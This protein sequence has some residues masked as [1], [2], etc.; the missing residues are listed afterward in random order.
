MSDLI[1]VGL[2]GARRGPA[3]VAGLR[4]IE[5]V[6]VAA[7]CDPNVEFLHQRADRFGITRRHTNFREMLEDAVDFVVLGTPMHLHTPQ[8]LEALAAGKHVLSEVTAAVSMEQCR[9]LVE[10]V[11]RARAHGLKYMMAENSCYRRQSV[12]I[13]SMVERGAFGEIY[14]AE[15]EYVHEIRKLHYDAAGGPTWRSVWQVGV[16]GC[17]YGTH[18]LGPILEWFGPRSRVESVVCLGSGRHTAPEHAAE[19]TTLMLCKTDTGALIKIRVDMISSRPHAQSYQALQGTRACYE[20]A[21]GFG[22]ADKIWLDRLGVGAVERETI[23]SN[24][25]EWRPLTEFEDEFLPSYW[26]NP[27]PEALAAGH[28]GS[29][30]FLVRDM[31]DAIR[32]DTA[33]PIDVYRALDYTIPGLLSQ[34]SIERGGEPVKAPDF[35]NGRW[36]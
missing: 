30:Y 2:A 18:S 33:P 21:R 34:V 9:E 11:E 20:S 4:A 5:G 7:I 25:Y 8:T 26:R 3:F 10:G 36:E 28:E 19:D 6:E 15:G 13:K 17:T 23:D 24:P 27:P 29:D 32:N 14:F 1:R 35:R 12:L 22:D 16:N 31:I